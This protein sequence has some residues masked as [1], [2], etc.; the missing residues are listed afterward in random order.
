MKP[1]LSLL[2]F[3]VLIAYAVLVFSSNAVLYSENVEQGLLLKNLKCNYFTG[4]GT[5]EKNYLYSEN[6]TIGRSACPRTLY[7]GQP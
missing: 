3:C 6:N 4:L 2:F 1:F 7:Y 5:M